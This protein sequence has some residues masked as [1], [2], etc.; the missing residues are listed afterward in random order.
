MNNNYSS[1]LLA[2]L[3]IFGAIGAVIG[4]LLVMFVFPVF[5]FALLFT[6]PGVILLLL[7][8]GL[9]LWLV[10][11]HR[12]TRRRYDPESNIET[13]RTDFRL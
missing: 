10:H 9:P 11:Q 1:E 7:L 6:P 4:W 12:K 2:K 8:V 13:T 5:L 3:I